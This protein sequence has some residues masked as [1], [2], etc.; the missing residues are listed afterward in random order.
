VLVK[1]NMLEN[2]CVVF[3]QI[4]TGDGRKAWMRGTGDAPVPEPEADAYVAR[5]RGYDEDLWV[6]EV[7]DRSGQLPRLEPIV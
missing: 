6:I 4:R 3:T 5:Q 7:E 1:R 2:G